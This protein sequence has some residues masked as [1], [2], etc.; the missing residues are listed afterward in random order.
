M[1]WVM[2]ETNGAD[3]P[4]CWV[5]PGW[6]K[7]EKDIREGRR[8]VPF[9]STITFAPGGSPLEPYKPKRLTGRADYENPELAKYYRD[10]CAGKFTVPG[11]KVEIRLASGSV[12]GPA[13]R[14]G[15]K[16]TPLKK[17]RLG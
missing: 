11:L 2:S 5:H 13:K 10:W 15:D 12:I 1:P 14:V 4:T 9:T 7:Y 16:I 6:A 8:P 3:C 17:V